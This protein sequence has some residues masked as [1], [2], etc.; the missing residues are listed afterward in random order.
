MQPS[1]ALSALLFG[2]VVFVAAPADADAINLNGQ[3][4]EG[5]Q[6]LF[7]QQETLTFTFADGLTATLSGGSVL[8]YNGKYGLTDPN[9]IYATCNFCFSAYQH[10]SPLVITFNKPV[11]NFQ[12]EILDG[13]SGDYQV[14]DNSGHSA[15][16]SLPTVTTSNQV[17]TLALAGPVVDISYLF[18]ANSYYPGTNN[19]DFAIDNIFFQPVVTPLPA[20]LPMFASGLAGIG[21]LYWRRKRKKAP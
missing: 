13:L 10:L 17:V 9:N 16:A 11:Q 2:A 21:G 1:C 4:S 8:N 12:V 3:S 5:F 15:T 14:S 20:A 7:A 19:Y 6:F 18:D